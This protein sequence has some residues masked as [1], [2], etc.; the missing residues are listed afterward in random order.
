MM[1]SLKKEQPMNDNKM[2]TTDDLDG[3]GGRFNVIDRLSLVAM[4]VKE[5]PGV[6]NDSLLSSD[7]DPQASYRLFFSLNA[8]NALFGH[9]GWGHDTPLNQAE[10]GGLIIGNV[11]R[12]PSKGSVWGFAESVLPALDAS[13]SMAYLKLSHQCWHNL[14]NQ[15]DSLNEERS[16]S[17]QLIGW[18]H[19]H[20][21]NLSVFMSGTDRHTQ[22]LFFNKEWHFAAVLNPQRCEWRVFQG[23]EARACPGYI[24]DYRNHSTGSI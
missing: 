9:I 15:L 24:L 2:D 16:T 7:N 4:D 22:K 10:Q 6:S 12:D 11:Y 21:K 5:E 13:G 23:P 18:Y 17:L 19:T 8:T 14:L 3:C 20:P 1:S